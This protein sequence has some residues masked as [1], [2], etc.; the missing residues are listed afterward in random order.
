MKSDLAFNEAPDPGKR[1][2][3]GSEKNKGARG[4]SLC[5]RRKKKEREKG[6]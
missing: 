6:N 4:T 2:S 1:G 3:L 5:Q